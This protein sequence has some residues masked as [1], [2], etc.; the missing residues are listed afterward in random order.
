MTKDERRV[1]Q[2]IVEAEKSRRHSGDSSVFLVGAEDALL[3]Y[4][5]PGVRIKGGAQIGGETHCTDFYFHDYHF[6]HVFHYASV[7]TPSGQPC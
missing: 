2:L 3:L 7:A 4:G 6:R 5:T 1:V